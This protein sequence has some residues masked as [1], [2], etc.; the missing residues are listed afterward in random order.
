[1]RWIRAGKLL[2][3]EMIRLASSNSEGKKHF[4]DAT[5]GSAM[6]HCVCVCVCV[7]VC[8]CAHIEHVIIFQHHSVRTWPVYFY[9]YSEKQNTSES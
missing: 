1:M 7:C 6:L 5:F 4:E 2:R 9:F 8:D 3:A